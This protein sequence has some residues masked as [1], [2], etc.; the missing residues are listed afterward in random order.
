MKLSVVIAAYNERENV[1]PLTERL[2]RALDGLGADWELV[3]VV[4][5]TDGTREALDAIARA[6]PRVRVLYRAEPAGLGAAFRRGFAA[7]R[8][9]ADLVLTMDADLNHQPE[10]I[11]ALVSALEVSGADIVVGSRFV[12]GSS[13]TG[14]PLWKRALST[15]M[16]A[17]MRFLWGLKTRDKTSGFRVYRAPALRSLAFRNDNFAFLPEMLIDATRRGY[18]ILEAPIRFTVRVHGVSKMHILTT[19]RSYLSLLRSR[20]DGWSLFAL[21]ALAGGAAVRA[22]VSLAAF[23]GDGASFRAGA[24]AAVPLISGVLLLLVFFF[25]ARRLVGRQAACFALLVFAFPSPPFLA[26]TSAPDGGPETVLLGL[27]ALW[28]AAESREHP[29]NAA[30]PVLSGLA[31]GLGFRLSLQVLACVAPAALLVWRSRRDRRGRLRAVALA[32]AGFALAAAAGAVLDVRAPISARVDSAALPSADVVSNAG[33]LA[34]VHLPGLVAPG[35]EPGGTPAWRRGAALALVALN[36]AA[37][38][39]AFRR[40]PEAL[41]RGRTIAQG[42]APLALAGALAAALFVF[43]DAARTPGPAARSLLFVFPLLAACL[44]LLL[45]RISL[46]SFPLALG[47][48]LA[49]AAFDL[50]SASFLPGPPAPPVAQVGRRP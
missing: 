22:A 49:V 2:V 17:A 24:A 33:R 1:V 34:L 46:R 6:V 20:W 39:L 10:E 5:G 32:A 48:G 15:S 16:N 40:S 23:P 35:A 3:Y 12:A 18:F 26:A 47:I 9:D 50:S 43:S 11:P 21:F 19:S 13:V 45:A 28:A 41:R 30:L 7:V 38:L 8:P 44:G 4:E 37:V 36:V 29:E 31:G 27:A 14:I 42:L 25:L